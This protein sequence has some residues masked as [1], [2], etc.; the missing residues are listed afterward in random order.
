MKK[1]KL[2]FLLSLVFI[3]LLIILMSFQ[4]N[5][6]EGTVNSVNFGKNLKF[7]LEGNNKTFIITDQKEVKIEKGDSLIL[8]GKEEIYLENEI[9]FV[10]KIIKK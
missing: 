10:E 7:Y 8:F 4:N 2:F 5:I 3:F 9:F 6:V 1:D